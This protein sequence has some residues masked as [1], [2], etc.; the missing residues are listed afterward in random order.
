MREFTQAGVELSARR[1]PEGTAE[2]VEVLAAALDAA[3]LSRAVIGLGDADLYR[4]LL[5][6]LGVGERRA[7]RG[8]STA[9]PRH[10]LV[11]L[12]AEVGGARPRRGRARDADP[13]ADAARRAR[14]ARAARGLGGEVDRA[15]DRAPRGDLRGAA[16]ARRRRP[17]P[18]RPRP[19]ARPRLL[20]RRDPR[21][22]RPG[23][24]PHPR[25]RRPLRRAHGPLRPPAA[26]GR[27]RALPRAPAR[28]PGRGGASD[29]GPAERSPR[30]TRA[31][32]DG[33][34]QARGAA[35]RAVR[36]HP[37]P[38][39]PRSGSRPPSCAATRARWSSSPASSAW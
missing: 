2:V 24:R 4:Q 38:A 20:H 34:L 19:A 17:G 7:R 39:R 31:G 26:G 37:R 12:E 5:D 6:E 8:S 30:P 25:R 35:R 28:R 33:P 13:A 36:G 3:G 23:A 29:E 27:L 15:R 32:G 10:D 9:S 16:R 1:R 21:G 22:L 18:P 14:G 11:G